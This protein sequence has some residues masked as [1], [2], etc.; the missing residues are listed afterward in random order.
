MLNL[1][2][3]VAQH[4]LEVDLL[5]AKAEGQYLNQIPKTVN[6]IDFEATRVLKSL[7]KLVNYLKM[8]QPSALISAIE[9]SNILNIW[10]K[11]LSGVS[12]KVVITEH[13]PPSK[14]KYAGGK[15]AKKLTV[16]NLAMRFSYPLADKVIA[17]SQ[18]VANDLKR[19]VSPSKIEVIHNPVLRQEMFEKAEEPCPHPW[20]SPRKTPVILAIGRLEKLKDF[21]NL[22]Q[23][24][25]IL[26]KKRHT[27]L[28]ILGEGQERETLEKLVKDLAIIE[29]VMMPGFTPNPYCYIKNASVFVLSS[30]T[31]GL[32]TVL[33]E[34]LALG[35]PVVSTDCESGPKE[36]LADGAYGTLVP[37]Q[38]SAAMALAIEKTLDAPHHPVDPA[39]LRSYHHDVAVQAYLK[40]AGFPIK[41]VS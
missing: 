30:I 34:A 28:V 23:A 15:T 9:H 27:K 20:F 10:A 26:R 12:T 33:I 5:L 11:K 17:V 19:F 32:P 16:L 21:S 3:A 35:T 2:V 7:P 14:L 8:C 4:G 24:F 25:A 40:V 29:D 31:E 13:N 36:I 6:L 38:D 41:E 37:I 1:A 22:I 39:V 18:G